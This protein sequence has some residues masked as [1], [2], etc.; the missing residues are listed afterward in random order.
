MNSNVQEVKFFLEQ[1]KSF[2]LFP[3]DGVLYLMRLVVWENISELAQ[4]CRLYQLERTLG[5]RG[6]S[7]V[8][9]LNNKILCLCI[10]QV[11]KVPHGIDIF[12]VLPKCNAFAA[13]QRLQ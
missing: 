9:A 6:S 12:V 10:Y 13:D 4:L 11:E 3:L 1:K 8:S 7:G 5:V 2:M